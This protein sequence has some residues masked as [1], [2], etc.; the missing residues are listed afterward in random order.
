ML[1]SL[2]E[3][4]WQ[5]AAARLP[6]S[7]CWTWESRSSTAEALRLIDLLLPA[8]AA[9]GY[10]D[11]DRHATRLALQEAI[12][13]AVRHGNRCDPDKTVR[14]RLHLGP[15]RVIAEVEDQ[16]EGFDPGRVPDPRQPE[17]LERPGGRGLLMMRHYATWLHSNERGNRVALCRRR[18]AP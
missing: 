17:N 14:V 15:E 9:E 11:E 13:N 5:A 18:S 8:M 1:L 2:S 10:P 7:E 3:P 6:P 16:G 4:R 12:V